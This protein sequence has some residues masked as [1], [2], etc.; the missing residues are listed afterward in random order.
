MSARNIAGVHVVGAG[1]FGTALADTLARAGR[2]VSL[3]GRGAVPRI[4]AQDAV[5]LAVPAAA[6]GSVL[7][8]LSIPATAAVVA[9]A[10]GIVD[11]ALQSD[12]IARHHSGPVAIL[13]GP[14]FAGEIARGLPTA[15]TLAC[16]DSTVGAH[17]QSVLS[18][19]VLRL[20]LSDDP[21]GAQVGGALK[22]VTAIA[23]GAAIGAGLGESA[24]AALM[25]RGYAE[26][27]RLGVA[28]GANAR[29][30][31]G[32]SGLGDLALTCAS[33]RSRNFAA[34][35]ALARDGRLPDGVTMEGVGTARAVLSLA[36]RRDVDMPIAAATAAV[37]D[38]RATVAQAMDALLS[39]PLKPE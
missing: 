8:Q 28:L 36:A 16:T 26:M 18:T 29:T 24:R 22:N 4:G 1:A 17:L 34:G 37:L 20:Y 32:L 13:T 6:T 11:E 5:L 14:S 15:L 38:G 3:S 10:K 23:C 12:I 9:C 30:F 35:L 2:T 19:P 7:A 39:R 31:A 25:T 33:A 27:V 21:I